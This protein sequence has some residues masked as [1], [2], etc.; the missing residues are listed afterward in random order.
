MIF[1]RGNFGYFIAFILVGG[2]LGSN[3][4]A[5][6]PRMPSPLLYSSE[7]TLPERSASIWRSYSSGAN[8]NL[9]SIVGIVLGI[10]LFRRYDFLRLAEPFISAAPAAIS[11]K[12][13]KSPLAAVK[14]FFIDVTA[15]VR[16]YHGIGTWSERSHLIILYHFQ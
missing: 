9:A 5:H 16:D 14:Q 13:F 4:P 6:S 11:R 7:P 8:L 2:I 12:G 3:P 1:E 10:V 15:I